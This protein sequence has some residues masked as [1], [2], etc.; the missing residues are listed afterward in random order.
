MSGSGSWRRTSATSSPFRATIGRRWLGSGGWG[1]SN[2]ARPINASARIGHLAEVQHRSRVDSRIR[3]KSRFT[4]LPALTGTTI[5]L[6]AGCYIHLVSWVS[7]R[8][9]EWGA[10]ASNHSLWRREPRTLRVRRKRLGTYPRT[11][12]R[13]GFLRR[14]PG[15][16]PHISG[17]VTSHAPL[18]SIPSTRPSS[19]STLG[20]S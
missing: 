12:Y 16:Q 6:V 5:K 3:A 9:A 15:S 1:M 13:L 10:H 8:A 14:Q 19:G 11:A 2:A 4:L 20:K 18:A 17:N 7:G